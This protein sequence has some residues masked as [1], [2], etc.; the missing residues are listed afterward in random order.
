MSL[1]TKKLDVM[2]QILLVD[3]EEL[4]DR[5][6]A[7]MN[8]GSV[9]AL[10]PTQKAELDAQELR[11]ARGEGKFHPIEESIARVRSNYTASRS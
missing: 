6:T 3:N 10:T 11:H 5:M 9:P 4:L 8:S 1:E 7:L 2:Q